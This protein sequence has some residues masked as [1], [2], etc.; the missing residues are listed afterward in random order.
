MEDSLDQLI[1]QFYTKYSPDNI[2]QGERRAS[3]KKKL[4]QD[5]D[6]YVMQMYQKYAPDN[7]PDS[8]RL[9]NLRTKYIGAATPVAP[10]QPTPEV[11]PTGEEP[12]MLERAATYLSSG[13][14]GINR[15]LSQVVSA[16][17]KVIGALETMVG[18]GNY[19]GQAGQYIEDVT[20]QV[21]PTNTD[22]N[23]TF[24][25]VAQGVGQGLGMLA[26]A[27]L[28]G[29]AAGSQL[30]TPTLP[31]VATQVASKFATA[32]SVIGGS[33]VAAPEWEAAKAAGASDS[34]AFATLVKNY[35]VGQTEAIPI[36]N[37]LGRINAIT[38][39]KIL[40]TVKAMGMGGFEEAVQEAIQTYLTNEIARTDY[41]PD[42]DPLFQVLESA[43]V[44]G[45]VGM[46]LPG[47]TSVLNSSSPEV[48]AK[49]QPKI[50]DLSIEEA[51]ASKDVEPIA[52]AQQDAMVEEVASSV[53]PSIQDNEQTAETPL[54]EV[55]GEPTPPGN[56]ETIIPPVA[57]GVVQG[58]VE[59]PS[60]ASIPL[61]ETPE[62]QDALTKVKNLQQA[63]AMADPTQ[64]PTELYNQLKEAQASLKQ[65]NGTPA[66]GKKT[67]I[68]RQ[69]EGSVGITPQEKI[70]IS[71]RKALKDQIQNYYR[72]MD[73][74]VRKGQKEV[75]EKLIPKVQEAIKTANLTPRQTNAILTKVRNT[76]LYTPG[77]ISR[78]NEFIDR[79]VTDANYADRV[80]KIESLQKK[81]DP[82]KFPAA[83]RSDIKRLKKIHPED[84]DVAKLEDTVNEAYASSQS[85]LSDKRKPLDFFKVM[86]V[87]ADAK[88]STRAA[89]N[90]ELRGLFGEIGGLTDY[91]L[92][93]LV[94]EDSDEGPLTDLQ[95]QIEESVGVAKRKEVREKLDEISGYSRMAIDEIGPTGDASTDA[96]LAKYKTI[97]T[98]KLSDKELKQYIKDVDNIVMNGDYSGTGWLW[99]KAEALEGAKATKGI[100]ARKLAEWKSGLRTIAGIN[101]AMYGSSRDAAK[102]SRA[103]GYG[104]MMAGASKAD[105][106]KQRIESGYLE[107]VK[108]NKG[109]NAKEAIIRQRVGSYLMRFKEDPFK[110]LENKKN[111]LERSIETY[112][113]SDEPELGEELAKVYEEFKGAK[114]QEEVEA[115]LKKKR[116]DWEVVKYFL[117]EYAKMTDEYAQNTEVYFNQPFVI[118]ENYLPV[119]LKPISQ[120]AK[121][122]QRGEGI[123]RNAI[124]ESNRLKAPKQSG[125]SI[126]ATDNIPE[127]FALDLDFALGMTNKY[128]QM[129]YDIETSKYRM[130]MKEFF[131]LPEA[132]RVY[133]DNLEE[134]E[135][136]Y[137][138]AEQEN[139][140]KGEYQDG[141]SK[142]LNKV[143]GT[144]RKVIY[145]TLFGSP[146]K[147]ITQYAPGA[148]NALVQLG[149]FRHF[150]QASPSKAVELLKLYP[151]G[152]R[153][154]RLGGTDFGDA[155][156]GASKLSINKL[157]AI[158][159]VGNLVKDF[160]EV[161]TKP[162]V[163][164]DVNLAT[165]AWT[166][167]YLKRLEELGVT[168]VDLSTEHQLQDDP[169][170]KEAAQFAETQSETAFGPNLQSA[171]APFFKNRSLLK[172]LILPLSNYSI[173]MKD[174][175]LTSYQY[176]LT[177]TGTQRKEALARLSGRM[178]ETAVY[179]GLTYYIL[180]NLKSL[181]ADELR[182]I[183]GLD[184]LE[185]EDKEKKDELTAKLIATQMASDLNPFIVGETLSTAQAEAF[186]ALYYYL[187][188]EAEDMG[189]KEFEAEYGVP[190]AAFAH[191]SGIL[192]NLGL[193]SVPF[194]SIDAVVE[195][196]WGIQDGELVT[197][198]GTYPLTPEQERFLIMNSWVQ[199]FQTFG[200]GVPEISQM[201]SSIRGEE[202]RKIKENE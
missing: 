106:A 1:D 108:R 30:A 3:L 146:T 125:S 47:V 12:S 40:S 61:E 28:G 65:I 148:V 110:A 20:K 26:T 121:I 188:E 192:N 13:A 9:A 190:F 107:V 29:T 33:M 144:F 55:Q 172:D 49:I 186:N 168:D 177:G 133:G 115:I 45:M 11:T 51:V 68:Q 87:V 35:L 166:A 122:G 169:K 139:R 64:D 34:E 147:Y 43:K 67:D 59:E 198:E 170:R 96:I 85:V 197:P 158:D 44:G 142:A 46:I 195:G 74:G 114:T 171:N 118:E 57:E 112:R 103:S 95:R 119:K 154:A 165:R 202:K 81:L 187:S 41:D 56:S 155:V 60:V 120:S 17:L 159:K 181:G 164:G 19:A 89:R 2:P 100:V 137:S 52:A 25:N 201:L 54:P 31:N 42:R 189:R 27:G 36:T 156:Y 132:K 99:G 21:N 18:G 16:P 162:F 161:I 179:V 93:L 98:S 15:G 174:D 184:P 126:E 178:M 141:T 145:T 70:S 163:A 75:N 128:R 94:D 97:D 116:G 167:F 191:K 151:I 127:G 105:L 136:I 10:A 111:N 91:E 69:I 130:K 76:S 6:G 24:Q 104:E 22:V 101:R 134:I 180:R 83:E 77:S 131:K 88:A 23:E 72:G 84:V 182:E 63:F 39:G 58:V 183:F 73:K 62:Y 173:N 123:S 194:R 7:T 37:M 175:M 92:N 102:A 193:F 8:T 53:A 71:P 78:L 153:G 48:R 32:P 80:G 82:K 86:D 90:L 50:T 5:F 196:T 14:A 129:V 124:F 200:I 157:A 109:S 199:T 66:P 176:A 160:S 38:G 150:A 143:L 113:N 185:E 135:Q 4:S 149:G 138:N 140:G 152:S 117:D 79:T